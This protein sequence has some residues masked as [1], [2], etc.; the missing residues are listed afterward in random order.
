MMLIEIE[1]QLTFQYDT[2]VNESYTELRVE[3]RRT[4]HQTLHSFYLAVGPPTAIWRYVDWNGNFVHHFGIPNFHDR[5]EVATRSLVETHPVG[6]ALADATDVLPITDGTGPLLDFTTFGGPVIHSPELEA[7]NGEV[8][9]P[10]EAPL[11][12]QIKSLSA[13]VLDR[14]DYVPEV[15]DYRSTTDH[16]LATGAGVCQDFAHLLIGLLRL[17]GI[18]SRYVS[19]YLHV[20]SGGNEPS[21]SHAWVEAW[22]PT[23]DWL[24]IDP[25]HDQIPDERYVVVAHGRDYDDVPPNR[26]IFRGTAGETLR[27][28]V[29]TRQS[30]ERQSY[31]LQDE[32]GELDVPVFPEVPHSPQTPGASLTDDDPQSQQQQQQ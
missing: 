24:A 17:R 2:F 30:Q 13:F 1:H 3:P 7:L 6:K 31:G 18:P 8:G 20:E 16:L 26:G 14:F 22:S 10:T 23:A 27:A 15:S 9:V 11:G 4:P 25:T 32:I 29:R 19:G 21:Q 5:I 28:S 12:E